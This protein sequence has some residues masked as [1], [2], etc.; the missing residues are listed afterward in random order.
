M[1][2]LSH[3]LQNTVRKIAQK[4]VGLSTGFDCLDESIRGF[5][6]GN[7]ILV[8]ARPSNGK[9]SLALDFALHVGKEYNVFFVSLEMSFTEL[10]ERAVC[11]LGRLNLHRLKSGFIDQDYEDK[12]MQA[13]KECKKRKVFVVDGCWKFYPDWFKDRQTGEMPTNSLKHIIIEAVQ[14]KKC[15]LVIIDHLQFIRT[16]M[17]RTDNES[18]RLHE[19][20]QTLHELTISLNVPIILLSQLRRL[21]QKRKMANP[22]PS[23]DD[24]RSSGQV[25]EDANI[26][27]ILHRPQQSGEKSEIDLFDD[28]VEED[29]AL[30]IEK[31]RNGPTGKRTMRF[32]AYCMSFSDGTSI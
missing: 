29:V 3:Q 20:T 19:I 13:E 31:N 9:T 27:I 11:N 5:H 16:E 25:E 32:L 1:K 24:I 2:L 8:A 15:K 18:L 7:L 30:I 17:F 26:I 4:D 21:D 22:I 6:P 12:L 14:K 23:M 10:Q 28:K